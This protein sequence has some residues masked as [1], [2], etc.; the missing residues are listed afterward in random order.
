MSTLEDKHGDEDSNTEV[1]RRTLVSALKANTN[2][3]TTQSLTGKDFFHDTV[4]PL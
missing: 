4:V 3:F 2:L 1:P